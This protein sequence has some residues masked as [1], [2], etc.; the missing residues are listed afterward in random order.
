MTR[1]VQ[2]VAIYATV[3]L[4]LIALMLYVFWPTT[5]TPDRIARS[6]EIGN[7]IIDAIERFHS[8]HGQCPESL[9]Q[10]VPDYIDKIEMPVAGSGRWDYRSDNEGCSLCFGQG[11]HFYPGYYIDWPLMDKWRL[12][13]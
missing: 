6:K 3:M 4:T 10:L 5:W 2:A 1:R 11:E 12:D 13:S 9:T 7:R 8:D